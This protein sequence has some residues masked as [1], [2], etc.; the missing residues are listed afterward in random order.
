ERKFTRARALSAAIELFALD[1]PA[2]VHDGNLVVGFGGWA[3]AFGD[4]LIL[5]LDHLVARAGGFHHLG[6]YAGF[7]F[8]GCKP[9]FGCLGILFGELALFLPALG[10]EFLAVPLHFLHGFVV[11]HFHLLAGHGVFE[12]RSKEVHV[13]VVF[14]ALEPSAHVHAHGVTEPLLL[15]R[16]SRIGFGWFHSWWLPRRVCTAGRTLYQRNRQAR[17]QQRPCRF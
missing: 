17:R 14:I 12:G 8:V 15:I 10:H 16:E 4:H 9:F 2:V 3:V 1:G 13:Q 7:L 6:L 5:Q 11:G